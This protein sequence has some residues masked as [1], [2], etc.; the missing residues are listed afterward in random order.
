MSDDAM[1]LA[2]LVPPRSR[3]QMRISL[4]TVSSTSGG[5]SVLLDD[6]SSPVLVTDA[7][8][9]TVNDRVVIIADRTRRI[10]IAKMR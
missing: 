10:A 3:Q 8:G 7:C 2:G 9:A 5:M 6:T 4:G 1:R